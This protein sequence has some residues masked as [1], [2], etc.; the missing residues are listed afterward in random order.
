MEGKP[1]SE[2]D[3]HIEDKRVRESRENGEFGADVKIKWWKAG[4]HGTMLHIE[5]EINDAGTGMGN[6]HVLF[7]NPQTMERLSDI[8]LGVHSQGEKTYSQEMLGFD[9]SQTEWLYSVYRQDS[10]EENAD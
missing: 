7:F 8:D 3:I 2:Q 4:E 6:I 5:Y 10:K 1:L 9:P